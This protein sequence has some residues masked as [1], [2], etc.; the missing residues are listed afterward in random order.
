MCL[1]HHR[2]CTRHGDAFPRSIQKIKA[3]GY[4]APAGFMKRVALP[5]IFTDIRMLHNQKLSLQRD[6]VVRLLDIDVPVSPVL[7]LV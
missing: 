4:F 1:Y 6:F 3:C 5:V 2:E 7:R